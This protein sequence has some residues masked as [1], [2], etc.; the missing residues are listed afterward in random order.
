MALYYKKDNSIR[1]RYRALGAESGLTDLEM[2]VTDESGNNDSPVTMTELG[3]TGIYES[4][5]TPDAEGIWWVRISSATAE[6]NAYAK[7]FEVNSWGK[8]EMIIVDG[9]TGVSA[10][11]TAS[12]R[13][14][15]SQEPPTPPPDTTAVV[16]TAYSNVANQSDTVYV[17]PAGETLILQRFSAGGEETNAGSVIELWYDPNGT[18]GNMTIIDTI[19]CNGSSDQHDLNDSY[20]GDGT[21]AIR[22]RRKRLSGGAVSVFGRW[23]G[24]Y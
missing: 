6:G 17:I 22:M 10:N 18:G 14:Q 11:V 1:V 4:Q 13:L 8:T 12:G 9:D 21:K 5:F 7:S 24:Y 19:F 2:V 20:T 3:T 15:V 16:Q 23:E